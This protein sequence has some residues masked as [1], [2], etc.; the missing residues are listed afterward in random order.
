MPA[1]APRLR[2]WAPVAVWMAV[3][4][5]ASSRP[6][7]AAV[8]QVPDW[9]SH[10]AAYAVLAVLACRALAGGLHAAVAPRVAA[11]AAALAFLYGVTDELHQ[12]Y[13]PGRFAE[14]ADLAKNLAGAALGAGACA[15]PRGDGAPRRKAA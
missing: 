14:A 6:V 12:S 13:V 10:P 9:I 11:Q 3:I 8:S 7:P 1:G 15:I 4:F 2:L 5:V